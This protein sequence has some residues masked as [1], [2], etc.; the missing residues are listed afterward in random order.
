MF[1]HFV[2]S[3]SPAHSSITPPMTHA[4]A[5]EQ[6]LE[7]AAERCDD[8]VPLV[9][10]HLFQQYPDMKE[11]FVMDE[12]GGAQGHMFNLALEC[13]QDFLTEGTYAN[14]FIAAERLNHSGYGITDEIF[15]AF[16]TT[17]RN[18]FSNLAG[19]DWTPDMQASW[20]VITEKVAAARL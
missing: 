3:P 9:Y 19:P 13:A 4:A 10:A 17:L 2:P 20:Q 8:P 6:S 15:E 14:N 18:V 11:L 16:Y 1:S 5:F 12:D 7:L